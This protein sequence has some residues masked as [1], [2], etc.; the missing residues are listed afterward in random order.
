MKHVMPTQLMGGYR[1]LERKDDNGTPNTPEF[2]KLADELMTTVTAFRQKNDEEIENLKKKLNGGDVVLKEHTDRINAA[3]DDVQ[4]KLQAEILELKRKAI[5]SGNGEKQEAPELVEYKAAFGEYLRKGGRALEQNLEALHAKAVEAKA[6]ATN[7]EADGGFTVLPQ[8]EQSLIELTVL[9]S[10]VRQ[11][12]E[13]MTI[14]SGSLKQPVNKRG[15]SG[16][17]VGETDPRTQTSTSQLAELEWV[18]G[19]IWAMPAATQ[20]MLDDS[21]LNVEQWMANEVALVFAQKEGQ[22]FIN[23]DGVKKPKGF[24]AYNVVADSS[25]S[26]GNLG[27]IPTGTSGAFTLPAAGPPIVQGA[28]VVFDVIAA[29]KYPFRPNAKWAANRRVV[30]Q[31]RKLKTLYADYLWVPGLQNGQAD[32]FAGYPL[33]EMEDMPDIAA[34]S[35]SVAFGDFKQAYRIVDRVGIRTLRDPFSSKPYVLF[36]TTK[37]VGGG[38]RNFEALKLLKFSVS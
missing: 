6:L 37:R 15:T 30:A 8:M 4:E 13:V 18:P 20:T 34:S 28:D 1:P 24:L 29:L 14:G 31:M 22:A 21:F 11:V 25:W 7:S 16:G 33:V 5:F 3:I 32:S 2:K 38:M 35:Y 36:Y 23:G 12:A 27:Y 10:P 17:W 9:V 26:W 19:E